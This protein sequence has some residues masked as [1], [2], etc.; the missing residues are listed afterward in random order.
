[1]TVEGAT[2]EV[3]HG[4]PRLPE[5][6]VLGQVTGVAVDSQDRVFVF[7]RADRRDRS[8]IDALVARPTLLFLDSERG[9]VISTWGE[10]L[11][12]MPHGLTVDHEDNL[13]VTDVG[14]RVLKFNS[15]G[16]LLMVVGE[17]GAPGLDGSHFNLPTDVAVTPTGEFY[18]TDGYG[19][20]RVAKFA[21]DGSFLFD[22]GERGSGPGQFHTPHSITLDRAGN[23]YVADRENA[24]I[25][26]FDPH[27]TFI[28]Q[29]KRPELGRPWGVQIGPDNLLYVADGGDWEPGSSQR[30]RIL[31]LDLD[32]NILAKW[33]A[34]GRYDGQLDWAHEL[35]VGSDGSVYVGDIYGMRIQKFRR[36]A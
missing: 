19:N 4:W 18:V 20:S 21:A 10:N 23:V 31:I 24:R 13:W 15:A 9:E 28:T 34:Y 1:M 32:G 29:W 6:Y 2:Y 27:G 7:H 33:G 36:C 22:W 17:Y 35:A 3:V 5:E 30:S 14:E 11:F 16:E 25:Q 8:Q 12:T 26:V